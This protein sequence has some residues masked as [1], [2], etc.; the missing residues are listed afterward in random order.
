M[1][2]VRGARQDLAVKTVERLLSDIR[3]GLDA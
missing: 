1:D 3:R 2:A